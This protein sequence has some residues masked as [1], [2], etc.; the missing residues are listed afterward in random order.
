MLQLAEWGIGGNMFNYIKGFLTDR[1]IKVRIGSVLSS[2]YPQEEGIP[3]GSVLSPTLFNIAINSLL[4]TVP[5]GVQG[6]AY[7]DDF[8]ILCSRST[9]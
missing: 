5:V 1:F 7:A 2:A 8:A 6:L 3:Q 9:A 4:E